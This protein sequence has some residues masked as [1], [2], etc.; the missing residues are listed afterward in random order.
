MIGMAIVDYHGAI[1]EDPIK[2]DTP[3]VRSIVKKR[4]DS[5]RL[6]KGGSTLIVFLETLLAQVCNR[7]MDYKQFLILHQCPMADFI[8][9]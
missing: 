9:G 5:Y 1:R 8:D 3:L 4:M 7:M 2:R 6:S